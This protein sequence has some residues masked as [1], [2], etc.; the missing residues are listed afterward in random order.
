MS[1]HK[2]NIVFIVTDQEAYYRHGWDGGLKPAR[3]NFE[4]VAAEGVQFERAYTSCPLCTPARR[5]ML[6]GLLPHNHGFITL[7]EKQNTT[8]RD[9]GILYNLLAEQGYRLYS[10][11]KWHAGPGTA[12]DFGCEGFSY[13]KFGNPYITPEYKAYCDERGLEP[14]R[15][16]VEHV[17]MEPVSPDEPE[18]GPGYQCLA[19]GLHP[20]ITGV[21]ETPTD[22]H[23]AQFLANLACD[24]LRELADD[25][26]NDPFFLRVDIW[27][28]HAPYL[29]A[30]EFLDM[31]PPEQIQEYGNFNDDLSG[32]PPVYLKEWNE[33]VGRN[34][35]LIVPSAMHW[36][37]WQRIMRY[38]YAQ[39]TQVDAACGKII[40]TLDELG[41]SENTLVIWTA[42]HGDAVGSFG[43]HFSKEAM[44]SEELLRVPMVMRWPQRLSPGQKSQQLVSNMDCPATFL[45][46]A[47]TSF[48]GPVDAQSLLALF[49][50]QGAVQPQTGRQDLLCETHGHHWEPVVG[51]AIV[52]ERYRYAAYQYHGRPDYL[53]EV[54]TSAAMEELYDLEQDPYQLHNLAHDPAAQPILA[55]HRRRLEAWQ[56]RTNDPVKFEI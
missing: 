52:S 30:Q 13:P 47:G 21:M 53:D 17:F 38:V 43:G 36:S 56:A 3:P 49:D 54:D 14:A 39:V 44:L 26:T 9:H 20:H 32:K 41:L 33:P 23:E 12:K 6:T 29:A 46:A 42:D 1:H 25:A 34:N 31:Y 11:G 24:K 50:G 19:S 48:N 10:Y 40:D 5:S 35:R 22:S 27:G 8:E 4:R 51:R 55:S 15:F 16:T 18:P 37:E 45:E 7:D 2:P 28:P